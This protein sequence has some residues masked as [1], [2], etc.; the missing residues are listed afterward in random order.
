M[1][2]TDITL[3][4][5]GSQDIQQNPLEEFL[6][7]KSGEGKEGMHRPVWKKHGKR[8]FGRRVRFLNVVQHMGIGLCI[9]MPHMDINCMATIDMCIDYVGHKTLGWLGNFP[10]WWWRMRSCDIS[11][12]LAP[13][14]LSIL[15]EYWC[16]R[17]PGHDN[18][19]LFQISSFPPLLSLRSLKCY[20]FCLWCSRINIRL[21]VR[22][23]ELVLDMPFWSWK[24]KKNNLS[25][26]AHVLSVGGWLFQ[27][28]NYDGQR[29]S[30]LWRPFL[31]CKGVAILVI[32][33]TEYNRSTL[34]SSQFAQVLYKALQSNKHE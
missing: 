19:D 22:N 17:N 24:C 28:H 33:T 11:E 3:H 32:F 5:N 23:M 15:P 7:I 1:F 34:L 13:G 4:K 16:L 27:F 18:N 20:I 6:L 2:M 9:V 10:E 29:V 8:V 14:C 12:M 30:A 21:E 31:R 26:I 25:L